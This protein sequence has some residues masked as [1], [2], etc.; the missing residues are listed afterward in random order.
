VEVGT[1]QEGL[2]YTGEWQ[3]TYTNHLGV[4][5]LRARWYEPH[6][7]RFFSPDTVVPDYQNPSSINRYLYVLGNPILYIDPSGLIHRLSESPAQIVTFWERQP[8]NYTCVPTSLAMAISLLQ[9]RH[10][11]IDNRGALAPRVI[12]DMDQMCRTV[13]DYPYC[14]F[15][16]LMSAPWAVDRYARKMGWTVDHTWFNMK[17]DLVKA[18][19]A[20]QVTLI[21]YG[22]MKFAEIA[23]GPI[24]PSLY[25]PC[26]PNPL[27]I[28]NEIV[29][30]HSMLLYS[31]DEETSDFGFLDPLPEYDSVIHAIPEQD[32]LSKWHQMGG[33]MWVI[34]L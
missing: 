21:W 30:A 14:Y 19:D 26:D 28:P 8:D 6:I 11:G 9:Y 25:M 10:Y 1:A 15:P 22:Q 34:G 2:G 17:E 29:W 12:K 13:F 23:F 7:G 33:Q 20:D 5:Y 31:Y 24:V 3:N 32:F 18:I 4:L 27:R 16:G